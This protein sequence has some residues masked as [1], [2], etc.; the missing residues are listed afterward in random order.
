M[1]SLADAKDSPF[2]TGTVSYRGIT[3]PILNISSMLEKI[4]TDLENS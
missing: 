2:F 1:N 3:A 4:G